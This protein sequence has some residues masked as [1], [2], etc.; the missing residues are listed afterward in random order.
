[1]LDDDE[2]QLIL[3]LSLA[4]APAPALAPSSTLLLQQLMV[5]ENKVSDELIFYYCFWLFL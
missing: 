2:E 1:L 3:L 4:L 5:T